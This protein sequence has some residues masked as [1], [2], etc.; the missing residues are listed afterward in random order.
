MGNLS[1]KLQ[2]A[3]RV[4]MSVKVIKG[5]IMP[6]KFLAV[7]ACG[8]LLA[9][10]SLAQTKQSSLRVLTPTELETRIEAYLQPFIDGNNFSGVTCMTR[11]GRILFQKGF[12]KAN[13]EFGVPNTP[14]TRFHIASVSKSFTAA[15]ILLLE[16]EGKLKTSDHLSRFIPDYPNG[17]KIQLEHLLTHTSG[18]P[19]V[20]NF[21]EY[22]RESRFPHTVEQVVAIFKERPLDFDPGS[23]S[24]YSNSNYNV[25]ALVIEKVS[26]QPFG[27]FLRAS[28]ADP[29][30]LTSIVHDGDATRIIA[31]AASGTEPDGL[32]DVK[33][34]PPLDWSIK[35]GNGSLV[36]AAEDLCRFAALLF[37]GKLLKPASLAK[38]MKPGLSFPYGWS[39]GERFG[40]TTM[41]V[42]G[43]SPGF[44]A[45]LEY[46][47]EDSVCIAILTNSYSSVGQVIAP[48][49]GAIVFDQ[50]V[51]SPRVAFVPPR[52]GELAS[53]VGRYRMPE[54]YYV[55]GATLVLKD[56]GQF[57]EA[58]WSN[59]ATN[60]IYPTGGDYFVDRTYWA[61][62]RFT[63]DA[64]GAING[65]IYNLLQEFA[66]KKAAPEP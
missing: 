17:E 25:L 52:E 2:I 32:R 42:G 27:D 13:Y 57:L 10:I 66:A 53:F 62:V 59:G 50:P 11:G 49:I 9:P 28:I 38:V 41:S 37:T 54:N 65:F 14:E 22:N 33:L 29:H 26:G 44:I 40:R 60:I 24:Q 46:F 58:N 4:R 56:R 34:A 1:R 48:D 16:E 35:V 12:G 64:S 43:R 45:H 7:V 36:I 19:N 15:A 55:P 23:R 6:K 39:K 63:R 18:I 51:I 47:I 8:L 31:K 30:G 20:N 5:I 3:N 61:Q 21:P